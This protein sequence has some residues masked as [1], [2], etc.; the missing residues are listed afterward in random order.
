MPGRW[1]GCG[2]AGSSDPDGDRLSYEWMPYP[3]AGTYRGRLEIT[4]P[5]KEEARL[6]A[7]RVE[8]PQEAHVI[9]KV[10]DDGTPPLTRYRRV[11]I[12]FKP[13]GGAGEAK[14]AR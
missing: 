12:A 4:D 8:G 11:R 7:P 3:E 5:G 2:A 9:L 13:P 14:E 10:R 6:T 1:S